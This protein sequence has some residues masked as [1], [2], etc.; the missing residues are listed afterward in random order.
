MQQN[1]K[2][3]A[4]KALSFLAKGNTVIIHSSEINV[5][6]SDFIQFL[7]EKEISVSEFI[8][9]IVDYLALIVKNIVFERDVILITAGGETSFAC[10]N[11]LESTY[12]EVAD[13]ITHAIPLCV[14][15]GGQYLVTKSGNLGNQNT[16]IEILNYF[17]NHE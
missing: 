8:S 4:E 10:A 6:D 14:G 5:K 11:A 16:L 13:A 9:K 17:K 3:I 15:T 7:F 1:S 2:E 12:L